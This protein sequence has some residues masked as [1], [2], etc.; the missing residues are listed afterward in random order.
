MTKK[1]K[2]MLTAAIVAL[3]VQAKAADAVWTNKTAS[4]TVSW[5]TAANWL[6]GYIGGTSVD[7]DVNLAYPFTPTAVFNGQG[8]NLFGNSRSFHSVTGIP[9]QVITRSGEYSGSITVVDPSP[10]R[11]VWAQGGFV[12]TYIANPGSG[13]TAEFW[14]VANGYNPFFDV[15]AGGKARIRDL[16]GKGGINMQ[17]TGELV[18]N[19]PRTLGTRAIV[20]D[21]GTLTIESPTDSAT[22]VPAA[23]AVLH[24]DAAA[25]DTLKTFYNEEDGRTYVTNWCDADGGEAMAYA[26]LDTCRPFISPITVNDHHLVDFGA[27]RHVGGEYKPNPDSDKLYGPAAF[28]VIGKT[29]YIGYATSI[30]KGVHEMFVVI[31]GHAAIATASAVSPFGYYGG[32]YEAPL[33]LFSSRMFQE[34]STSRTVYG[35]N[36]SEG[37]YRAW[38]DGE[39]YVG[40]TL[41][42]NALQPVASWEPDRLH[43]IAINYKGKS[44][45]NFVT[46]GTSRYT[47]TSSSAGKECGGFAMAEALIYTT[48]L[49]D[50]E[51]RQTIEYLKRKWLSGVDAKPFDLDAAIIGNASAKV[52]VE[53]GNTAKIRTLRLGA[54]V[55]GSA[56]IVKS[57]GGTLEVEEVMPQ[58]ATL[59]VRG[60]DV[61]LSHDT[62]VASTDRANVPTD[63]MLCWLDATSDDSKFETDAVGITKWKDCRD[64]YSSTVFA[65]T[66]VPSGGTTKPTR[67]D[68][69]DSGNKVVDY[70]E[71]RGETYPCSIIKIN[72]ANMSN[73]REAFVVW[74]R[75]AE[76]AGALFNGDRL[77]GYGFGQNGRLMNTGN[78]GVAAGAFWTID[79]HPIESTS[80]TI[81]DFENVGTGAFVVI[82]ACANYAM[83]WC[84]PA[85]SGNTLTSVYRG[86]G[87]AIGE[88]ITYSRRLSD[89]ER[90]NVTAYLMN[91]WENG[92]TLGLDAD[93][94]VAKISFT[95]GAA[96]KVGTK[97]DRTVTAIEGSGTFTKTGAGKLT[98][99]SL[100]SGVT[101]LDIAEGE[102]SCASLSGIT[103]VSYRLDAAGISGS[104]VLDGAVT[105]PAA[106]TVNVAVDSAFR[107]YGEYPLVKVGSFASAPDI[108]GWTL[109]V[110]GASDK[111]VFS[112]VRK[113]DGIYLQSS[114]RGFMMIFR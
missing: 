50:V 87:C 96:P 91:K 48:E 60:G 32:V 80:T 65:E 8:V 13:N 51:R 84:Y 89:A 11:G 56:N 23:G 16:L 1:Q 38:L 90:R 43:V 112:L 61:M 10:F 81:K 31:K 20:H 78:Y 92:A 99:T 22:P 4:G 101:A 104:V 28:M 40:T 86:G 26:S 7:D 29:N 57:G 93:D 41:N 107:E 100:D 21:G 54:N 97:T 33:T 111:L 37:E 68:D 63:G 34:G 95:G 9:S 3:A 42:A 82:N 83:P 76:Y 67:V 25:T 5:N 74:R 15:A 110:G 58:S 72:G 69:N 73:V 49:T 109:N 62:P 55:S 18:L 64:G 6:D 94:T 114:R 108:S 103:A 14:R 17:G 70:G 2:M 75:H 98:V 53:S 19:T 30:C 59:E 77:G 102:F 52:N 46:L 44:C 66:Y 71:T 45:P 85:L 47:E 79:G 36:K 35:Y 39:P 105:L 12:S 113:A 24:F 106:M 88:I 27:F